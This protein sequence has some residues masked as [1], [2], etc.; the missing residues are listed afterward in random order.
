MT[1]PGQTHCAVLVSKM[2]KNAIAI[3]VHFAAAGRLRPFFTA[4]LCA[5]GFGALFCQAAAELIA[6]EISMRAVHG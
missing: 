3:S 5:F 1:Y 6:A 4:I 2:S